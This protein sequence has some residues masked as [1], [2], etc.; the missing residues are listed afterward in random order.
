MTVYLYD[1]IEQISFLEVE[2]DRSGIPYKKVD[3]HC[4]RPP[5][6]I[7]FIT[8]DGVPLD[9]FRALKWIKENSDEC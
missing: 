6:D 8:V 2:L 7:P 9:F 1:D 3:H 4:H 5:L